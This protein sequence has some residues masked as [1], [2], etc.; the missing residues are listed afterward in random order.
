MKKL[1]S[2]LPILNSLILV[3]LLVTVLVGN[4]S[5]PSIDDDDPLGGSRWPNGVSADTTL[6][7]AGELRGTTLTTTGASTLTLELTLGSTTIQYIGGALASGS[8]QT[9]YSNAT[10]GDIYVD[11]VLFGIPSAGTA[12]SSYKGSVFATTTST[13][14]DSMD[15]GTL[16]ATSSGLIVN[17]VF[18]TSTTATTTSSS[19]SETNSEGNEAILVRTT[20]NVCVYLQADHDVGCTDALCESATSTNRGFDPFFE[21]RYRRG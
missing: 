15:F 14:N 9:C 16:S 17:H 11:D 8:D 3:T 20:E 5:V 19:Y 21:F 1:L 2:Y 10:G 6:P 4:Q 7:V 18:A 12:S 13:I